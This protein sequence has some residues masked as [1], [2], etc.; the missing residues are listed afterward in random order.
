VACMQG[1]YRDRWCF[2]LRVLSFAHQSRRE[3]E[4]AFNKKMGSTAV[5]ESTFEFL[6]ED[7][8]IAKTGTKHRAP[9]CITESGRKM[10]EGLS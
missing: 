4:R 2:I 3:L 7:G 8:R 9:F 5:F 6:L 10:L 1:V